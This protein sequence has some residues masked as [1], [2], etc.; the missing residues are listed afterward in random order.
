MPPLYTAKE[1]NNQII[2][3]ITE[4][5]QRMLLSILYLFP[6]SLPGRLSSHVAPRA[7]LRLIIYVVRRLAVPLH[8]LRT[9]EHASKTSRFVGAC[10]ED[11]VMP[12]HVGSA[13][14]KRMEITLY[15]SLNEGVAGC[16]Q[17]PDRGG[18]Q[19]H[20]LSQGANGWLREGTRA[21]CHS[22]LRANWQGPAAASIV[23]SVR[24]DAPRARRPRSLSH[25]DPMPA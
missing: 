12:S 10:H 9:G 6:Q 8:C 7:L 11:S 19:G 15:F 21:T 23:G 1:S 3:R 4:T 22:A 13:I 2:T 16:C 17:L 24:A 14:F 18:A 25:R 20:E 5:N